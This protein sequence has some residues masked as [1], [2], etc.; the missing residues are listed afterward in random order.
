MTSEEQNNQA[1]ISALSM[2]NSQ[3][4]AHALI[5]QPTPPSVMASASSGAVNQSTIN[6]ATLA[7]S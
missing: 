1:L 5:V 2:P 4:A 6:V 7:K 3:P